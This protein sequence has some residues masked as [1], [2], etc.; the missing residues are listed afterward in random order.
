MPT[1]PAVVILL[2]LA[3]PLLSL[4]DPQPSSDH[5][6]P[7][8]SGP[9][10]YHS[11]GRPSGPTSIHS[12]WKL[13]W[14]DDFSKDSH[15]DPAKW[16]F[17]INGKG[18]GNHELEYYTDSPKNARIENGELLITAI[19]NDDGHRFTSARM[20]TSHKFACRYGRIEAMIKAPK[21]QPGNWPA[22]WMLPQD[23]V[24][25][26]WPRSGEIDIMEFVN[27]SDKLYGT[28]HYGGEHGDIHSGARAILPGHNFTENYHLYAIEWEPREIRWYVDNHYYGCITNWNSAAAAFPA[29]FDQKFCI[30]INYAVGGDW[31]KDPDTT[32]IFPQSM[33]VKY[34]RVYQPH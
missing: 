17:E 21:A 6:F 24:Y 19:Q 34:V 26:G 27:R 4:A 31:P 2:T 22:F 32:S 13:I 10:R 7:D 14:E 33:H 1:T 16:R 15:I 28:C 29:P 8:V 9:F 12:D 11:D 20:T 30:I 23:A 3:L 18:G 5:T 25:G